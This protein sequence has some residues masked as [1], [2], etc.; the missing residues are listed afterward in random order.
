MAAKLEDDDKEIR[1]KVATEADAETLV[2]FIRKYYEFDHIPFHEHEIRAGLPPFLKDST[3]GRAWLVLSAE[4]V[5][6]YTIFTFSFDLE[7]GGRLAT[8]TDLYFEEQH[9]GKG[10]GRRTLK[11]IEEFCESSDVLA[12]ELRVERSNPKALALYQKFGFRT[13]DRI[14]M[15]KRITLAEGRTRKMNEELTENWPRYSSI[16]R[17]V[18]VKVLEWPPEKAEEFIKGQREELENWY[19]RP[20]AYRFFFDLPSAYL[21]RPILGGGLQERITQTNDVNSHQVYKILARAISGGSDAEMEN[22]E[23]DWIKAGQRYKRW[24]QWLEKWLK[25]SKRRVK[26]APITMPRTGPPQN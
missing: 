23:F 12:L 13:Y 3:L 20:R 1:Y 15:S 14:P 11:H 8:I 6:G 17:N 25:S 19:K 4:K 10:L 24:R 26:S 9:R 2:N 5:I 16:W 7:L 22:E 21:F 18:L